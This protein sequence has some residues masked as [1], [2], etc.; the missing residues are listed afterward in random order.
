MS[1]SIH[2]STTPSTASSVAG[3]S[4]AAAGSNKGTRGGIDPHHSSPSHPRNHTSSSMSYLPPPPSPE[5]LAPPPPPITLTTSAMNVSFV[6]PRSISSSSSS[7]PSSSSPSSS[8]SSR[9]RPPAEARRRYMSAASGALAKPADIWKVFNP[10]LCRNE[11]LPRLIVLRDCTT[12]GNSATAAERD[13]LGVVD[14]KRGTFDVGAIDYRGHFDYSYSA[15]FI[16][17]MM[18]RGSNH[19]PTPYTSTSPVSPGPD[20][21]SRY[22]DEPRLPAGQEE[23]RQP[24]RFRPTG[25][26]SASSPTEHHDQHSLSRP[27]PPSSLHVPSSQSVTRPRLPSLHQMAEEVDELSDDGTP[28]SSLPQ[29]HNVS[30]ETPSDRR[31]S[32]SSSTRSSANLPLHTIR[33]TDPILSR[34]AGTHAPPPP[35]PPTASAG[36]NARLLQ[37]FGPRPMHFSPIEQ[38]LNLPSSS[39][40]STTSTSIASLLRPRTAAATEA[41]RRLNQN[42]LLRRSTLSS[43]GGSHTPGHRGAATGTT[44]T[45]ARSSPGEPDPSRDPAGRLS[46]HEYHSPRSNPTS[47]AIPPYSP[48]SGSTSASS[49]GRPQSPPGRP[50]TAS[51]RLRTLNVSALPHPY[52]SES[53]STMSLSGPR[54]MRPPHDL[55]TFSPSSHSSRSKRPGTSASMD[56]STS[57]STLSPEHSPSPPHQNEHARSPPTLIGSSP[58]STPHP[59]PA[60]SPLSSSSPHPSL[61]T[62]QK[63]P[64]SAIS[65]VPFLPP[66]RRRSSHELH[67][68]ESPHLSPI[69]PLSPHSH[70]HSR[71]SSLD[72]STHGPPSAY[73][74]RSSHRSRGDDMDTEEDYDDAARR[75]VPPPNRAGRHGPGHG[76]GHRQSAS[77]PRGTLRPVVIKEEPDY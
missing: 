33:G 76:H 55:S 42:Q 48:S 38:P 32:A 41:E 64:H 29:L 49:S 57:N 20:P 8:S 18:R 31:A 73:H 39:S 16:R 17:P 58:T 66:A 30:P 7:G 44:A 12:T 72:H 54:Y 67:Q 35:A 77:P 45:A 65:P 3:S 28:R 60:P 36:P 2:L 46:A 1:L 68:G 62:G 15:W 25:V 24:A 70:Q 19:I 22:G 61:T 59:H 56:T 14:W 6:Y 11:E 10:A 13:T 37:N 52:D 4:A 69:T 53:M 27:P 43:A 40:S 9:R 74:Y 47:I 26:G 51:A 34:P 21:R 50:Q 75:S 5:L 23:A 71:A 63:R